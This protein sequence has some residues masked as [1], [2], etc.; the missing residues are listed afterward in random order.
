MLDNTVA[1]AVTREWL[2]AAYG[3]GEVMEAMR[4]PEELRVQLY[5][6][7]TYGPAFREV[8]EFFEAVDESTERTTFYWAVSNMGNKLSKLYRGSEIL[9]GQSDE[10]QFLYYVVASQAERMFTPAYGAAMIESV[11]VVALALSAEWLDQSSRD[12]LV[13]LTVEMNALLTV[14]GF[15]PIDVPAL[16]SLVSP[17]VEAAR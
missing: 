5:P 1:E 16:H 4:L 11:G 8:Q 17:V 10:D 15:A 14:V 9:R 3:E 12:A 2:R 7:F 13:P 6:E